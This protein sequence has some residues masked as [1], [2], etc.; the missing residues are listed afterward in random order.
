MHMSH[1]HD[2]NF[3]TAL[4]LGRRLG[5][6]LPPASAIHIFAM[7][8]QDALTFSEHMTPQLADGYPVYAGA[9]L[10]EIQ[11]LLA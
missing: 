10:Q 5:L 2:A 7:E 3:A 6:R 8:V 11:N 1:V 9:I 4:E